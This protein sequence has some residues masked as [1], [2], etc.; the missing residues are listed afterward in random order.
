[1]SLRIAVIGA[2]GRMGQVLLS[3]IADSDDLVLAGALVRPG[4]ALV[5]GPAG[6]DKAYTDQPVSALDSA[7]VAIDF[8]LPAAFNSNLN[9]CLEARCAMVIGTTGLATAQ[10]TRL[11]DASRD[12]PVLYGP[13][14]SIG[15]NLCFHLTEMAAAALAT[16]YDAEI[17]DE[18][19]RYKRDVP[20]GTALR[21]GEL[22]A[23]A[24]GQSLKKVQEFRGPG[25][26]RPRNTGDIGFSSVRAGA[27]PG[28]HTVLFS[29]ENEAI[30]IRHRAMHRGAFASGAILAAHWL[31][32]RPAGL[33]SM[34]DVL[35]FQPKG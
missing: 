25:Q 31:R 14:M 8:S 32:K 12:L 22:I 19:H 11:R 21:F 33:Y 17:I 34:N 3:T 1:M 6:T 9:A 28:K 20:S 24:R 35:G 5:G 13:N 18:H 23:A 2:G 7:E 26:E 10:M 27:E 29:S 15:V 4:S 16:D 30:E